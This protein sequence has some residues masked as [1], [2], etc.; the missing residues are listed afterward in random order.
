MAYA[1]EASHSVYVTP[2]GGGTWWCR[3]LPHVLVKSL[4]PSSP[5]SHLSVTSLCWVVEGLGMSWGVPV[6][7]QA[8]FFTLLGVE[9][10]SPGPFT[11]TPMTLPDHFLSNNPVSSTGL[12]RIFMALQG[13]T[14]H[15]FHAQQRKWRFSVV[16][17]LAQGHRAKTWWSC[18]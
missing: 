11:P 15:Y 12:S 10:S 8:S 16:K 7:P 13:G 3:R 1:R 5:S 6:W 17:L 4:S 2:W 14:C 18:D 9:I